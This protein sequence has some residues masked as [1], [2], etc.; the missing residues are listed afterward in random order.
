MKMRKCPECNRYNF[1]GAESD[2]LWHCWNCGT[3][4]SIE[5][6]AEPYLTEGTKDPEGH[7]GDV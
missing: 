2:E 7:G 5:F 6:Q 1:S 3:E 4:I